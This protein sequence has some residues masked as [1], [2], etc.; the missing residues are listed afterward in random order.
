[1]YPTFQSFRRLPVLA[2]AVLLLTCALCGA[3]D[4]AEIPYTAVYCFSAADFSA[5]GALDGI[6]VT[7]VP[8]A[9]VGAVRCGGR[10]LCAGDVMPAG[11]LS[12]LVL[13]PACMG[14]EEAVLTYLPVSGGHVGDEAALTV[15]IG[16]GKN[17]P[18]TASD[19]SLQTYKNIANTGKLEA[20]DPEGGALTYTVTK[21]PKR[22]TVTI[23]PDG[24][25][26]Y[27][28]K[29]NKVGKDS[30]TYTV[31]DDAGQTSA[32]AT[33]TIEILK[34]TNKT[35]Y[36]DMADDPD[37][38]E[39]MWLKDQGVFAGETIAG[40][41]CFNPDKTVTRGEFLVMTM[42]LLGIGADDAELTSGFADEAQMPDWLRPYVVSA[43][44]SG[45][46]NG[47]NSEAGLVFRG[48]AS[49][50]NA[51]AAVILQNILDLPAGQETAL[52]DA[53]SLPAWCAASI[54]AMR[55]NGVFDC[56]N[57]AAPMTRREV[58]CLLYNVSRLTESNHDLGLLAWAA[59]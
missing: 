37:Q 27:T 10:T 59:E 11:S 8:D 40:A 28:P 14:D 58:A 9:D 3:A 7:G 4:A 44:R 26:T 57:A 56:T 20:S 6:V 43:F 33:V 36:A 54:T 5:D 15:R 34:P 23:A 29:K 2:A 19:A 13:V 47:V 35:A 39:A 52:T 16:T 12:S 22:G 30:F 24:S 17:E 21:E 50:T 38:F 42:R 55:D 53:D 31:T 49:L 32:E 46:V 41:L 1:M 45:I 18:P 48:D 51:E 25:F